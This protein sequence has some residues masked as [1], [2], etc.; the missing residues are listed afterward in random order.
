MSETEKRL[1]IA[2][3]DAPEAVVLP[4]V[5]LVR[6]GPSSPVYAWAVND[7]APGV[8]LHFYKG[9]TVPCVGRQADCRPC[10][11]VGDPRWYAYLGAWDAKAARYLILEIT[12]GCWTVSDGL[13]SRNGSLR[14]A[15]V[16]LSRAQGKKRGL[17][18]AKI[19]A[20]RFEG[21][22]P[23]AINVK[24]TLEKMWFAPYLP[25]A[26]RGAM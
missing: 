22:L 21:E 5:D 15:A 18:V 14:G 17:V 13:R 8:W 23:P 19:H 9:R 10:C 24:L 6:V 1:A 20:K 3:S 12:F 16:E 7:E 2:W 11:E 25:K 4:K 26:G